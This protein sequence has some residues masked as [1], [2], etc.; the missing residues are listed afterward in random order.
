MKLSAIYS[1]SCILFKNDYTLEV[2]KIWNN[3]DYIKYIHDI[4]DLE[5]N[6]IELKII[7]SQNY[8]YTKIYNDYF[9]QVLKEFRWN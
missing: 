8:K 4:K 3:L 9:E 1:T 5:Q 7:S 6:M 2:N